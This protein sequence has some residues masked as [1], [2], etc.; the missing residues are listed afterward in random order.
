MRPSNGLFPPDSP[1]KPPMTNPAVEFLAAAMGDV[2]FVASET[3][4]T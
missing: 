4:F 3:P 2:I 1:S